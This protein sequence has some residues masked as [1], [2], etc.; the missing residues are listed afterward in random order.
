MLLPLPELLP[1][2]LSLRLSGEDR[3]REF[4]WAGVIRRFEFGLYGRDCRVSEPECTSVCCSAAVQVGHRV[5]LI[6]SLAQ[7]GKK[8][9][10]LFPNVIVRDNF[11]LRVPFSLKKTS[12][13]DTSSPRGASRNPILSSR[14]IRVVQVFVSQPYYLQSPTFLFCWMLIYQKYRSSLLERRNSKRIVKWSSAGISHSVVMRPKLLSLLV[15]PEEIVSSGSL[16]QTPTNQ[17]G[18]KQKL[19]KVKKRTQRS[20]NTQNSTAAHHFWGWHV[21]LA[22]LVWFGLALLA[23][24]VCGGQVCIRRQYF[25]VCSGTCFDVDL[26]GPLA[27][28]AAYCQPTK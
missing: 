4:L 25:V 24:C 2:R 27:S 6:S 11:G 20:R 14:R 26:W 5:N 22:G 23:F 9:G 21:K 10:G 16:N 19:H 15:F 17:L 12:L 3:L 28:F 8:R 7:D 13:W 1:A 18:R